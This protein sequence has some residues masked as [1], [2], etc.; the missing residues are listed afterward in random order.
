MKLQLRRHAFWLAPIALLWGSGSLSCTNAQLYAQDYQPDFGSLTG[1]EGDLCTDDPANVAFPL[2][3][4]VV[5]DG[6]LAGVLD[7]RGAA[8]NK[9]IGEY[10]G[11]NVEFDFVLMG[12]TA[13]SLTQGFTSDPSIIQT[14]VQNLAL[15]V[16]PLRD[17][18]AGLL[19]ATTDIESDILGTSPGLRSRSHY[20]LIFVAQGPPT[21][22]LPTLWC[23][24]NQ[25][26]PGTAQCTTQ[27]TAN[28][29]PSQVPPP[30]DCELQ[31]YD[32]LV[33]E[34]GTFIKNNG[35]LDF[36]GHFYEIGNDPRAQA[37]LSGM[38]LAAKGAFADV[39]PGTLTLL[40]TPLIDPESHFLL[41]EFVVWNANAILRNG[42]PAPDSDADGLTDDEE[43]SLGTDPT[44]PDTDGD[45]VGDK[46]EHAL[47][48][49]GSEF[50]PLVPGTFTECANIKIPFP[51]SDGDGLN[52][53]EEAVEGT[54]AFLQ[55]TDLDGLPDVLEVLRGAYPLVDDRLYDTDSDGML[56]G[57]EL[58][59]GTDPNTND[60]APA[61]VYAYSNS[62]VDDLADGG[63]ITVVLNTDPA[64]PFP[65]VAIEN[66]SGTMAG[67]VV[68]TVSPGPPLTL[69]ITDENMMQPGGAVDV[70]ASGLFTLLS[71]TG[72]QTVVKVD[73]TV[74]AEAEPGPATKSI[75]L[76][77]SFRSCFHLSVQ[78]IKLVGTLSIAGVD[79]GMGAGGAVRVGPRPADGLN[80]VNVY[81][82]EALNGD[83][84]AP[85]VYRADTIPFQFIPPNTKSP[86]GASITLQQNDLTTLITN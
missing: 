72:V 65:G 46:I 85:T 47:A 84:N 63:G 42:A 29:C 38:T 6:G 54:S 9:L 86:P 1:V 13:Q 73:A 28:F 15:N 45:G 22:S 60:S 24:A 8:L 19:Q 62:V 67:T 16:S 32:T 23:G 30:A 50:D 31:L 5:L 82:G 77:P 83:I 39:M 43:A 53:C 58:R 74:L 56:N 52:D 7:N 4:A 12:Q 71:P 69:A 55:D 79:A 14:A 70:S 27:F 3:I 80:V 44:N 49:P 68:L 66:I 33:T 41:R 35:A 26:M 64:F 36:I 34:L 78:N 51:D 81:L 21:P 2:K 25:L 37:I 18:E 11:A 48:Y 59:Q 20:A 75:T 17:Y 10:S 61:V 40:D 57:L 76:S